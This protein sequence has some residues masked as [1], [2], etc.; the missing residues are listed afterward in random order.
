MATNWAAIAQTNPYVAKALSTVSRGDY[1]TVTDYDAAVNKAA[2]DLAKAD[3]DTFQTAQSNTISST[4]YS[5]APRKSSAKARLATTAPT[6]AIRTYG[7]FLGG[8]GLGTTDP[9]LG[10]DSSGTAAGRLL[11]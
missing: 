3:N 7:A 2:T 9:L 1:A 6:V 11:G 5:F 8:T 10:A 4:P